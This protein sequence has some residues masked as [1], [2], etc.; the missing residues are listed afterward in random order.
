MPARGGFMRKKKSAREK[1][2]R[3][4]PETYNP[5]AH[6]ALTFGTGFLLFLAPLLFIME[7][8]WKLTWAAAA[9]LCLVA[10][11]LEY[12]AHRWLL[13]LPIIKRVFHD[14]A[15]VHHGAF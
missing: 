14:H 9:V 10:P 1:L 15:V 3:M 8:S 5:R 11:V 7:W 6:V 2:L 12:G 4:I 13:H